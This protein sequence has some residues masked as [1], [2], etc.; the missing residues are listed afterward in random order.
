MFI[1]GD[2][3]SQSVVQSL[4][5][6]TQESIGNFVEWS[7]KA[8]GSFTLGEGL[9]PAGNALCNWA[10]TNLWGWL[11]LKGIPELCMTVKCWWYWSKYRSGNNL[12]CQWSRTS[13]KVGELSASSQNSSAAVANGIATCRASFHTTPTD[14]TNSFLLLVSSQSWK[15]V[16]HSTRAKVWWKSSGTCVSS[17]YLVREAGS[18][19]WAH[20][21]FSTMSVHR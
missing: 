11:T 18:L 10:P 19:R 20:S 2:R 6:W 12:K 13:N 8:R 5:S 16:Q 3:S 7:R 21:S 4:Y 14:T 9:S 1:W 17:Q 15:A